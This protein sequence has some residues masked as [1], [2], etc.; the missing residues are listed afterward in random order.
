MSTVIA[1]GV[2]APSLLESR[3]VSI[4]A[5]AAE[6][7]RSRVCGSTSFLRSWHG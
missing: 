3:L 4:K 7:L 5:A 6:S 1:E 2:I